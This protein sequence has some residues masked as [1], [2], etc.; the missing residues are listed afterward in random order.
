MVGQIYHTELQLNEAKAFDVEA[1]FMDLDLSIA[2]GIGTLKT[3]DKQ[4]DFI[5][6]IVNWRYSSLPF[7]RCIYFAAYYVCESM[8]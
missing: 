6:E 3:Y 8:F 4:H 1:P 2:N 7:L 5:F